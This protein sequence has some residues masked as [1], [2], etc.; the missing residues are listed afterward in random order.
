[1]QE[2]RR[3]LERYTGASLAS[4]LHVTWVLGSIQ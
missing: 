1:L 4:C 3:M 2:G